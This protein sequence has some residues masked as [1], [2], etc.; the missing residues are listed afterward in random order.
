MSSWADVLTGS[1][2]VWC[3]HHR[4]GI[5]IITTSVESVE[6]SPLS[7]PPLGHH[8]QH[9]HHLSGIITTIIIKTTLA[10]SPSPSLPPWLHYHCYHP[11]SYSIII[12]I[13]IRESRV[14]LSQNLLNNFSG[15]PLRLKSISASSAFIKS[16]RVKRDW[17]SDCLKKQSKTKNLENKQKLWKQWK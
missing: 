4:A 14:I 15:Q 17:L 13:I 5:I 16:G 7:S 8:H 11:R 2:V 10:S 6:S 3:H 1:K 12:I 9:H